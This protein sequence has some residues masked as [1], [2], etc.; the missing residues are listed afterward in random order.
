MIRQ[1]LVCSLTFAIVFTSAFLGL[2]A[3]ADQASTFSP[4][5]FKLISDQ[6]IGGNGSLIDIGAA[7]GANAP[8][9]NAVIGALIVAGLSFLGYEAR[10]K[11]NIQLDETA[12]KTL[13]TALLNAAS[14]LVADGA[15]KLQGT[16]IDVHSGLLASAANMIM[17]RNPD[18]MKRLGLDITPE[19]I[20][21]MIIDKLPHVPAVA[22]A[23]SDAILT[24]VVKG[25]PA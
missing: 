8:I 2:G 16:K 19:K 13:Q 10:T 7:F 5:P 15:V 17:V 12:M 3:L 14:S 23:Q 21:A 6:A 4:E 1:F 20:E 24:E 25:K 18:T 11:W 9:I 22:Q